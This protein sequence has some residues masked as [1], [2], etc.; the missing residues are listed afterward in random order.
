[1]L[2]TSGVQ[3]RSILGHVLFNVVTNGIGKLKES[4]REVCR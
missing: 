2:V 1:M 4:H 3:Q